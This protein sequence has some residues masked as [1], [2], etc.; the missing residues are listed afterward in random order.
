MGEEREKQGR[1]LDIHSDVLLYTESTELQC[2]CTE[3]VVSRYLK[4]VGETLMV[5]SECPNI[6]SYHSTV[7]YTRKYVTD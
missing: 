2:Y 6:L 3:V 5:R 1:R 7:Q 4:R